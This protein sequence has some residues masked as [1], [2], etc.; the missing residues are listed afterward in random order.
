MLEWAGLCVPFTFRSFDSYH[1]PPCLA[2]SRKK[3]TRKV[4]D[5]A[6][7]KKIPK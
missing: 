2:I 6:I 4:I 3:K 5:A 1:Q 7:P